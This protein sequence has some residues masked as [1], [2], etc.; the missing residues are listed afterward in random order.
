MVFQNLGAGVADGIHRVADTVDQAAAVPGFFADDLAQKLPYLAVVGG[1]FHIFQDVVQLMHD[2]QVGAAVLGAFQRADGRRDGR[3]GVGAGTG[4]HPAG[5]GGAVA[6]AV[7]GVSQQAQVQQAGFLMGELL[8]GAVGAQD[9]F[10]RTLALGG[11]VEVHAGPVIHPALDLVGV[12]HHGGQLGVAV[13]GQHAAGHLVHQVGGRG[14]QDHVI[15]KAPG[16]FPVVFQ[17]FAELGVLLP[18]RQRAEQQ[19][20]DH[21][22]KHEAVMIVGLGGQGVDVDAPVDQPPRNGHNV[23]LVVAVIPDNAGYIGDAGQHAGAVQVAQAALD[24]QP[25]GHP[26]VQVGVVL[27][28]FMAEQ[29]HFLRLQSRYVGIIHGQTPLCACI[30]IRLRGQ[31]RGSGRYYDFILPGGFRQEKL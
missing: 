22:L 23:P 17:Q 1:I 19:K 12:D 6:A 15:G 21:F 24:P 5:E 25:V 18:V 28:V 27:Q 30:F 11:Q 31:R 8:V 2:L 7:V 26:G 4:Q 9:V 20:P 14:V 3:I 13:H 29:F 16:Q 10:R